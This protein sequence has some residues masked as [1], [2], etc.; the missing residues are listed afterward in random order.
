MY[1]AV[2]TGGEPAR[3]NPPVLNLYRQFGFVYPKL[4]NSM[5]D[6]MRSRS[7][8]VFEPDLRLIVC[9]IEE[10]GAGVLGL[11]GGVIAQA[12]KGGFKVTLAGQ[13]LFLLQ[14][15]R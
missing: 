13:I 7:G 2:G 11:D 10:A 6:T 9:A 1:D 12:D 15:I 8:C 4:I 5:N 14:Q 3:T